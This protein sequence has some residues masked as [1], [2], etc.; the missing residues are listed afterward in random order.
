MVTRNN[1]SSTLAVSLHKLE[2]YLYYTVCATSVL[3]ILWSNAEDYSFL[4]SLLSITIFDRTFY[5]VIHYIIIEMF[6]SLNLKVSVVYFPQ[7]ISIVLFFQQQPYAYMFESALL[8]VIMGY[9]ILKIVVIHCFLNFSLMLM[10]YKRLLWF[11]NLWLML[12]YPYHVENTSLWSRLNQSL[13][14][15][16]YVVYLTNTIRKLCSDA[17]LVKGLHSDV[18]CYKISLNIPNCVC[19]LKEYITSG[20]FEIPLLASR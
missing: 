7:N 4:I 18:S 5:I 8:L 2:V 6:K 19:S 11:C 1:S 9:K 14:L 10:G 17:D 3:Y 16:F 20:R 15:V 13:Y 12:L